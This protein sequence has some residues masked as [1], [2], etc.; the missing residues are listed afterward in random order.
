MLPKI[1]TLE[2]IP[3]VGFSRHTVPDSIL[4][5]YCNRKIADYQRLELVLDSQ[6]ECD[7]VGD[8]E[9]TLF[10][11]GTLATA[12]ARIGATGY[13]I[14]PISLSL[15]DDYYRAHPNISALPA[16]TS[17]FY[18]FIITGRCDGPWVSSIR[19]ESCPICH[20]P[21]P[22]P[23]DFD[24]FMSE[25]LGETQEHTRLV[26]PATWHGED[27]F[28]LSE[29]GPA[30]I[31]DRIA[32]LLGETGNLRTEQIMNRNL[33]EHMMPKYAEILSRSGWVQERCSKLGS[34]EWV[35]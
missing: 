13:R 26:D 32:S 3:V 12:L 22:Q 6:P 4:C 2:R 7:I 23:Q 8:S 11:S 5:E 34:A 27:L 14:L 20:Q 25:L 19:G 9:G 17:D 31:T 30:I 29:P 16:R 15:S 35:S 1:H 21:I 24:R 33:V 10:I 18:E 28:Y